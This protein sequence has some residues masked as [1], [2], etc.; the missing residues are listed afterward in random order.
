VLHDLR[1]HIAV[2]ILQRCRDALEVIEG[3][4]RWDREERRSS[5]DADGRVHDGRARLA[6]LAIRGRRRF[7]PFF[8]WQGGEESSL[9]FGRR[10]LPCPIQRPL[11]GE[12][13][14]VL[15]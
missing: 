14:R 11:K 5:N 3:D 15:S 13:W 1:V 8:R 10:R 6:P 2:G 9:L 12:A 4:C 7:G